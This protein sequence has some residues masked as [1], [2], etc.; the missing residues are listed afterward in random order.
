MIA[1]TAVIVEETAGAD[2]ADVLAG[3]AEAVEIGDI[4]VG[5]TCHLR[6]MHRRKVTAIAV[7][8]IGGPRTVARGHRHR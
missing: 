4:R 8:T 5:G 7:T 6:N 2:D 1:A 3:V